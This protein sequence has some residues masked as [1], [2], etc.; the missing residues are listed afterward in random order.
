MVFHKIEN[1]FF[2]DNSWENATKPHLAAKPLIKVMQL[3]TYLACT[4]LSHMKRLSTSVKCPIFLRYAPLKN[5]QR[6]FEADLC[7]QLQAIWWEYFS[8]SKKHI[9]INIATVCLKL[10]FLT[11]CLPLCAKDYTLYIASN[12]WSNLTD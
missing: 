8:K 9:F 4:N 3:W 10:E 11:F 7:Y 6:I 1:M 2:D 5:L 12:C